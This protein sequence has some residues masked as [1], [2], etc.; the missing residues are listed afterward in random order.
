MNLLKNIPLDL[1]VS[2]AFIVL[3]MAFLTAYMAV[4]C[5]RRLTVHSAFVFA[6]QLLMLTTGILT[7]INKV[8]SVPVY[9]IFL[10]AFGIM[11]PG[12]FLVFDYIRMKSRIKKSNSDV[13]L[14]EKFEKHSDIGWRYNEYIEKPEEWKNEIEPGIIAGSL[15]VTDKRLKH[16]VIKQLSA[17]HKLI[18]EGDYRQ[19][20][21]TYNILA[22]LLSSN[23]QILYNAAWL[24]YKNELYGEA[25]RYCKKALYIL[26]DDLPIKHKRKKVSE[27]MELINPAL[28]F[29]YGLSL[30]ALNKYVLAINQFSLA[31]KHIEE[32]REA[33]INIAKCYIAL[34]ELA[35]AQKHIRLA[36]KYGEDNKLRYLLARLCF[37]KNEEMECR[38]QLETIVSN[39][40][41]FTEAWSLLGKLYRKRSDWPNALVAYKKLTSLTPQDADAYYMLG[42]AQRHEGKTEDAIASF[43]FTVELMPHHSRAYYSLASVY[44]A[45]GKTEKAIEYLKKSLKGNERLEMAYNHLAEI[46]ISTDQIYEAILVYEEAA[47]EHPESYL[48]H[49][50]LGIS[51]MI[52]K[53]YE[54]AVRVFKKAHKL[55]SDD[56]ALY[57]NWASAAISLKNFSEAARLYKKGL[58][59]KEDDDEILFGLARVSALSGDVDAT[60]G[61]LSRAF[62][63][64]P[65]LRIRA[66][67]SH[68]FAAYRTHPQ[69]MEIT[70]LPLKEDRKNA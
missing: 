69:F 48:I 55:T 2:L 63:I 5:F 70:R 50:N 42:I 54:D 58:K 8:M 9:E 17:V 14:I 40:P 10:I 52:M 34:G 25:I 53:R 20:L 64:N 47:R 36:L 57:Y 27:E 12:S 38:H 68:D 26:G 15:E 11:L 29:I 21:E 35:E 32:L 66:K 60:I 67:S 33:D 51:L 56:P 45:Q 65:D 16:N 1:N 18:D 59:L 7:V 61:F 4:R 23:V 3:L 43:K 19:A 24:N 28:C 13:P 39:D 31:K 41:E 37:E 44:D 22:E 49:F 30:F 62:E 46:Y 6:I